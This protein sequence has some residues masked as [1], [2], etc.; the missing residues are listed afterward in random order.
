MVLLFDEHP[1][2]RNPVTRTRIK[3]FLFLNILY[4]SF[5]N[6]D[7]VASIRIIPVA[8][9]KLAPVRDSE[10]IIHSERQDVEPESDTCFGCPIAIEKV[11]D[12]R[13]S[14]ERETASTG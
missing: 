1:A 8:Q 5:V 12:A 14:A 9:V 13:S 6:E 10:T 2:I 7:F 11:T 3:L 4:F